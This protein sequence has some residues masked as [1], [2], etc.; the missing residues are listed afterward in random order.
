[1]LIKSQYKSIGF[2]CI[3]DFAFKKINEMLYYNFAISF[4]NL[5]IIKKFYFFKTK[6]RILLCIDR[7]NITYG[8]Y[9]KYLK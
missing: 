6:L 4:I 2:F 7:F 9:I 5:L 8:L 1:M 3:Y